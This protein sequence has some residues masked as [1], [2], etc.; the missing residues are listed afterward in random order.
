MYRTG[1]AQTVFELAL[2]VCVCR[3]EPCQT[4][5]YDISDEGLWVCSDVGEALLTSFSV[6][7]YIL[8]TRPPR[9][10]TQRGG[11]QSLHVCD[12]VHSPDTF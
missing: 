10:Q 2:S 6:C 12:S 3:V 1:P 5:A 4:R 11:E 8:F 9:A 7:T